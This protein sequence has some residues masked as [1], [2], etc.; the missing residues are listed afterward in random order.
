M[1]KFMDRN[2]LLS[3][4]AAEKL[5]HDFAEK[6]PVLDYHCH[7]SPAEIAADKTFRNITELWLGGDH[8]KWRI[9]RSNGA[10]EKYITGD[11]P[12]KDKFKVFAAALP[13]AVGNPMYH[14]CHLELRRYFGYDG[15]LNEKTWEEVWNLC[16]EKLK[17]PSMSAKN[18]IRMSNVTLVCTTD[19]PID[20]LHYHEEIAEDKDFNI[21]VL[22]AWRPDL[23]MSP[24]KEGFICY[25][26]KLG[27][28]SGVKIHTFDDWKKALVKRLDYFTEHGCVLTDHGLDYAEFET[29]DE[30]EMEDIFRRSIRREELSTHDL[31][32]FR[33]MAMIFLGRE[34]AARGLVMQLHYGAKR[35]NNTR[36][37]EAAGANSGIDCINEK[38]FSSQTADFL[39]ALQMTGELPKTIIYSLNPTD[40]V[41]IGTM[42]G[43]FQ[44]DGIRGKIQQGAAW[45]FN[46]H[47][48]GI[49]DQINSLANLGIL[50]NFIGML[51]DSRSFISYPRHEYFRR[52][53]CNYIGG[54]VENGEYPDDYE[55]LG[56]LVQDISYHN[57]VKYFGFP[58][59]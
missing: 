26:D 37:F 23:A 52:I 15:I 54:L 2:F 49:Q 9:M 40:N 28:V 57:A 22:P 45:W 56:K 6:Q 30:E 12:D 4:F 3:G 8:Y 48:T 35:E 7:L 46:D 31:Q 20:D 53:L 42:I 58:L 10:D 55:V 59:E 43:C 51:T 5:Y 29:A 24:E 11:A 19:D 47:K 32:V 44:G 50:G 34:Y 38:G 27:E 33:T 25:I 14:W 21:R 36:I 16:N 13:R 41:L 18:L 1:K 39:N 17:S